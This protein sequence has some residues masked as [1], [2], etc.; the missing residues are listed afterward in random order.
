MGGLASVI[1]T[2]GEHQAYQSLLADLLAQGVAPEAI[3]VVHNPVRS[4][5]RRVRAPRG[6][7]VIRMATNEGYARGMNAGITYH[8]N[9][10]AEWIWLLTHDVR[11][12]PGVVRSMMAAAAE[13]SDYGALGPLLLQTGTQTFF[14]LSGERSRWGRPYNAGYGRVLS[15]YDRNVGATRR[16]AWLDG[17]SIML[18]SRAI[19]DVGLYNASL[20]GYTEDAELCLR[21][22]R[23]GWSSGVVEAAVAE[24]TSG[25]SS[26]P[27]PATFLLTRNDLYYI[28]EVAG[29]AAILPALAK[30][31]LASTRYMRC[32]VLG[33]GRRLAIIQC[34][35][36]WIGVAA[37]FGR[38]MGPPPRW[39]PGKGDLS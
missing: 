25:Q 2:H 17:S 16:C 19:R 28:R 15:E 6:A 31:L 10:G 37:F 18:R 32:A 39:L 26:R 29:S 14:S 27:G 12:W 33:P 7:H 11:L 13:D 24:Q 8:I 5:D 20:F 21:L 38:R 22:E 36:M 30:H 9:R 1:L 4:T 34:C 3:C 23:A 35:A